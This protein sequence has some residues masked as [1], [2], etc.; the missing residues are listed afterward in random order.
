MECHLRVSDGKKNT[1][2]IID[3]ISQDIRRG[4]G[5]VEF[6]ENGDSTIVRIKATTVYALQLFIEELKGKERRGDIASFTV[7]KIEEDGNRQL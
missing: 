7:G 2:K 6:M 4:L 5:V 3:D 1:Q